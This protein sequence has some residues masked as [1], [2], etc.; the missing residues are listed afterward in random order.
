ML[1]DGKDQ[2]FMLDRDNCVFEI[3]GL[4]FPRRKEPT[5]CLSQTLLDGV[6][7]IL[8]RSIVYVI[9]NGFCGSIK[10]TYCASYFQPGLFHLKIGGRGE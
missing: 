3:P 6:S 7:G 4:M 10:Y 1:I 9:I 2:V 8:K 5:K